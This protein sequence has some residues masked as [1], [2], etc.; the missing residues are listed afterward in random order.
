MCQQYFVMWWHKKRVVR[1]Q[2]KLTTLYQTNGV[3]VDKT[4]QSSYKYRYLK[5]KSTCFC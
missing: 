5:E 3:I 4:K 1:T 2:N